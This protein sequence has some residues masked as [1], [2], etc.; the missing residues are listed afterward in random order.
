MESKRIELYNRFKTDA[1]DHGKSDV[2]RKKYSGYPA[3]D[4]TNFSDETKAKEIWAKTIEIFERIELKEFIKT[5][6]C[7]KDWAKNLEYCKVGPKQD[8]W[9]ALEEEN[10][11]EFLERYPCIAGLLK[12]EGKGRQKMTSDGMVFI[13]PIV[14][15]EGKSC[16]VYM[17]DDPDKPSKYNGRIVNMANQED[18]GKFEC[19]GDENLHD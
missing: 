16:W 19:E 18:V 14:T 1:Q 3:W 13:L 6:A 17:L 12:G 4:D 15:D 5:Y 2:F 7:D 11:S 10:K 9:V 8:Q